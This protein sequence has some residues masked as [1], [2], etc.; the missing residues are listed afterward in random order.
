MSFCKERT[1]T[2]E[3][4]W[5]LWPVQKSTLHCD[6]GYTKV[7]EK[8]TAAADALLRSMISK[9]RCTANKN[10]DDYLVEKKTGQRDDDI[11][12]V[13]R[14]SMGISG[15]VSRG[16]TVISHPLQWLICEVNCINDWL[17]LASLADTAPQTELH[18]LFP[19]PWE[20]LEQER[21]HLQ[22]PVRALRIYVYY[23]GQWHK[24]SQ[25]LVCFGG[26]NRGNTVT[27][28]HHSY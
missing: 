1:L 14:G 6:E 27:K 10:M 22:C 2:F 17:I 20:L 11:E 23:S 8:A 25:L 18:S 13:H 3:Q 9:Q 26:R 5:A 15:R 28:Q 12:V 21:L 16:M 4:V 7:W 19:P 24:S